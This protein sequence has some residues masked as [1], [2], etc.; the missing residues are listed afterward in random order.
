MQLI[1]ISTM[2]RSQPV[3]ARLAV[4]ALAVF[5]A[6]DGWADVKPNPYETIVDRNPF[7]L[8][9][10]PVV[11]DAPPPGPPPTPPATVEITGITSVFQK[12]KVLLEITPGPGK[13][14]VRR[15][16]TEGEREDTVEVVSINVEKNE[17]VIRNSGVT[18]NM[19]LKK[20]SAVAA[21]A[22]PA[23]A[24]PT[25]AHMKAGMNPA[26]LNPTGVPQANAV[27]NPANQGSAPG[28]SRGGAIAFGA[29]NNAAAGNSA[30]TFGAQP[31]NLGGGANT[32]GAPNTP[33]AA[34]AGTANDPF[35]QIPSRN[36]RTQNPQAGEGGGQVDPAAQWLEMKAREIQAQKV[37][38][39]APP[40][41]PIPG[42][43]DQ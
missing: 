3:C 26:G 11:T 31:S 42:L 23:G 10:P 25:P 32:F 13:P 9:P 12:H 17:V 43:S 41:P 38:R 5:T 27:F 39:P 36:I 7:A 30:N 28:S 22:A 15:I 8:R 2:K 37:G 24:P 35:R 14:V 1:M 33:T 19:S 6:I 16:L 4:S 18:T 34:A 40:T 29:G 20:P 21:A